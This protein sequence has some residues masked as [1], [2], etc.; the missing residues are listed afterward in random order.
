MN[1][2]I[3]IR[4]IVMVISAIILAFLFIPILP[5]PRSGAGPFTHKSVLNVII[6]VSYQYKGD[7]VTVGRL[8]G[9]A[10]AVA[11]I[12][13]FI[14]S[15][16]RKKEMEWNRKLLMIAQLIC[17]GCWIW[18]TVGMLSYLVVIE[19]MNS[20]AYGITAK[21]PDISLFWPK[22]VI[23]L[24][25]INAI[26]YGVMKTKYF[27]VSYTPTI[28]TT[29]K[30]ESIWVCKECVSPNSIGDKFCRHC[31]AKRPADDTSDERILPL[32]GF[33]AC[34]KCGTKNN[35]EYSFCTKC[36]NPRPQNTVIDDGESR[37]EEPA[38][39]KEQTADFAKEESDAGAVP[40]QKESEDTI[41]CYR[42]GTANIGASFCK[43]CG[44][45][46]IR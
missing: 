4:P 13:S 41:F 37:P 9:I 5:G 35:E 28:Y 29:D 8:M 27:G 24:N 33:W 32:E 15:F 26:A 20:R 42:C 45:K 17:L 34:D 16:D 46:L 3:N 14:L 10:T 2:K 1:R 21:A 39:E 7:S 36:G 43:K 23:F 6:G 18:I 38:D 22:F 31:G 25:V 30:E 12:A 19:G 40:E 44:T 11:T